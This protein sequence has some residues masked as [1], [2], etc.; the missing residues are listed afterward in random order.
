MK[1]P[2]RIT[3]VPAHSKAMF[4]SLQLKA[5]IQSGRYVRGIR[6]IPGYTPPSALAHKSKQPTVLMSSDASQ[7]KGS[8]TS[9]QPPEPSEPVIYFAGNATRETLS[10]AGARQKGEAAIPTLFVKTD[11]VLKS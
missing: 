8:Y 6:F 11:K 3:V 5:S 9:R 1:K 4:P 2:L 7:L 10:R